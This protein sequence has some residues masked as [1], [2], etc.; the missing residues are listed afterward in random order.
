MEGEQTKPHHTGARYML[1]EKYKPVNLFD[2]VP[3]EQDNVLNE[4]DQLLEEDTVFQAVKNDL[5]QRYPHTLTRGRHSKPVEVILRMLMVKHLYDW[6]YEKAE[7]FVSDSITL[8]RFC[9]C[10]LNPMPDDTTLIKWANLIQPETLHQLLEHVVGLAQRLKVSRGRKLRT[11]G[12][13]VESNIHHPT[14]SSLLVDGVQVLSRTLSRARK[15][16]ESAATEA[17]QVAKKVFRNRL[18]SARNMGRE[19]SNTTRSRAKDSRDQSRRAYKK[20]IEITRKTVEQAQEVGDTLQK[21]AAEEAQILANRLE[22]FLPLVEQAIEQ[23]VR[24]V[25]DGESVPAQEKIVSIFEPHTNIIRRGKKERPTEFGHKVWLDE[26]EG[27][28]ISNYRVLAGNPKDESQWAASLQ[29]HK[30][31]FGHPPD[32]ASA[33]HR[34]LYSRANEELAETTGV[35]RV[36]L[37]KAGYRSADRKEHEKQRWF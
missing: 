34:G 37:P 35:R 12:T 11:D 33:D 19:I 16:I 22:H 27:G 6:S 9:R 26:V 8:R 17:E 14:D 30:E 20:L 2:L 3:L 7:A 36:I 29:H 28:I 5:A 23:S 1:I 24:R 21:A 31:L 18:R 15:V 13:V 32:Q 4:L 25:L 10:Y